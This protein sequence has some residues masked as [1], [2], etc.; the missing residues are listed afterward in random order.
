MEMLFCFVALIGILY[1]FF[2]K[3]AS[4]PSS[5]KVVKVKSKVKEEGGVE[6]TIELNEEELLNR[7]KNS[8]NQKLETTIEDVAGF[9]GTEYYSKDRSYCVYYADGY[10][11]GEKWKNGDIALIKDKL[12]LFKKKVKRPN[13]CKVS[14][15][16]IVVCCDWQS[17]E[18]TSGKLIVFNSKGE[19]IFEKKTTANLGNCFISTDSKIVI[20]ETYYSE[21]SDSNKVFVVDVKESKIINGFTRPITFYDLKIDTESKIINLITREKF[22]YK[23]NFE[24]VHLNKDEYES[25]ILEL[26]SLVDSLLLFESKSDEEKFED[27]QYLEILHKSLKDKD[28]S[29]YFGKDKIYRKIGEYFEV[30]G[31]FENTIKYWE[32]ALE[33]NPK[34]GVSRKLKSLKK[35][36]N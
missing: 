31:E 22:S 1:V 9:Y 24:G 7:I 20:F 36:N 28:T 12:L 14:N 15:S 19:K 27:K 23:V 29:E 35:N 11:E 25:Q 8:S 26:G 34:V 4:I 32:L 5:E 21:T 18:G 16:G 13:D 33:I 2:R 10:Y 3:K 30:K 6:I 17:H